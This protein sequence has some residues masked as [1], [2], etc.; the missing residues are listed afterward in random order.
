MTRPTRTSLRTRFASVDDDPDR[1]TLVA[2]LDQQADFPAI[3]RLRTTAVEVL[4][5]APEGQL[6]DA[7][8]GI[9]DMTRH[10]ATCVAPG[11][12]VLGVDTSVTM[13]D[14]ARRRTTDPDLPAE[15]RQGDVTH[16]DVPAAF[17]DGTYSERVFQHL[18][19]AEMALAELA[20]V[21]RPGGRVVV[22]DTDWGMHAIH[23]ANP[24]LTNAVLASWTDHMPNGWSGRQ[25]PALFANAGLAN[26]V[27]VSDTIT[28]TDARMPAMEP[29]ATMASVA[30]HEGVLTSNDVRTWLTQLADASSSG[31][32][33]W[34]ITMFLVAGT[35][36]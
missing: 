5:P 1:E 20:R 12:A 17:F 29:F 10:L 35:R 31:S 23:G 36:P 14:E 27:V 24:A 19:T 32:F 30:E 21:T 22:V 8:C 16:L 13:I 26:P 3:Q 7:G 33:F 4:A 6:L 25:L 28:A 9:G 15:F 11:G 18:E 34:A 2:A